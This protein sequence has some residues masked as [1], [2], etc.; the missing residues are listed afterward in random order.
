MSQNTQPDKENATTGRTDFHANFCES[1]CANYA[2]NCCVCKQIRRL[3]GKIYESYKCLHLTAVKGNDFSFLCCFRILVNEEDK[4]MLLRFHTQYEQRTNSWDG[5]ILGRLTT[6]DPG[7]KCE[8]CRCK[9]TDVTSNIT[10]WPEL[11]TL[12]FCEMQ[13]EDYGCYQ[14]HDNWLM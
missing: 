3:L 4:I 12:T 13:I 10:Q 8:K 11:E 6:G 1:I 14:F 5:L 9:E 2:Y 7:G